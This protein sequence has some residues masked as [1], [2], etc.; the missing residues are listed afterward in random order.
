METRIALNSLGLV[1]FID[2]IWKHWRKIIRRHQH[3]FFVWAKAE[4]KNDNMSS[5]TCYCTTKIDS[6][7]C[8]S[9]L[10]YSTNMKRG[11]FKWFAKMFNTK[12][13]A[14][15]TRVI[16]IEFYYYFTFVEFF[17]SIHRMESVYSIYYHLAGKMDWNY[18]A[19]ELNQNKYDMKCVITHRH[20]TNSFLALIYLQWVVN[21][22]YL[23]TVSAPFGIV[24]STL[25]LFLY[26][27][28][29]FVCI[30]QFQLD[31]KWFSTNDLHTWI[32]S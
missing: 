31:M 30:L 26:L 29:V 8:N 24:S 13:I 25:F 5:L 12:H 21:G 27:V 15:A 23:Q 16:F 17:F 28:H 19:I 32:G 2:W 7:L 14:N 4:N 1:G 20:D 22:K 18:F 6:R 11:Y 10:L 9:K 3:F